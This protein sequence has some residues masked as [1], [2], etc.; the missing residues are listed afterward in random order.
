MI[1]VF[2][3]VES[4]DWSVEALRL[5]A[6]S[7]G[8]LQEMAER[9]LEEIGEEIKAPELDPGTIAQIRGVN[10]YQEPGKRLFFFYREGEKIYRSSISEIEA[11][12][13]G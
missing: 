11:E 13:G 2:N 8:L 1:R 12:L 6:R 3:G 9:A 4:K 10:V 7:P 5:L